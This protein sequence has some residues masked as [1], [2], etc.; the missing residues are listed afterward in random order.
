MSI[1][2][3]L[4]LG[5]FV[6]DEHDLPGELIDDDPAKYIPESHELTAGQVLTE[7]VLGNNKNTEWSRARMTY[8]HLSKQRSREAVRV[9]KLINDCAQIGDL[10]N[11]VED[12]GTPKEHGSPA[13]HYDMAQDFSW[14][15]W[16][17]A[18]QED[19]DPIDDPDKIPQLHWVEI[20]RRSY[21]RLE[22][23][24][25]TYTK[26]P[27]YTH[28]NTIFGVADNAQALANEILLLQ[29]QPISEARIFPDIDEYTDIHYDREER[30]YVKIP[31]RVTLLNA[32]G[33]PTEVILTSLQDDLGA[34]SGDLID[35]EVN[36]RYQED[37]D[38]E[39]IRQMKEQELGITS[40][41]YE[42]CN[43]FQPIVFELHK[44]LGRL[45]EDEVAQSLMAR[46]LVK[47]LRMEFR[48]GVPPQ[49]ISAFVMGLPL[50]LSVSGN[51]DDMIDLFG[52][53]ILDSIPP[54]AGMIT[55]V[56][57]WEFYDELEA[58]HKETL[59]MMAKASNK[60]SARLSATFTTEAFKAI[61]EDHLPIS[62]AT[63]QAYAT[64]RD[65]SE[66]GSNA[67]RQARLEK[68]SPS[69][70]M[71]AFYK[72]AQENG[73]F[74]AKDRI[75]TANDDRVV[76]LTSSSGYIEERELNWRLAQ[77][78]A[79]QGEIYIAKDA[80]SKSKIWLYNKLVSLGWSKDLI[81]N[82]AE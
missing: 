26:D 28:L 7:L 3:A 66:A 47:S 27:A 68:K 43:K 8:N 46:S 34:W 5:N 2:H 32:D 36:E 55:D 38:P 61:V 40:E 42:L 81:A 67:F 62:K 35:H 31:D 56:E 54:A 45:S 33:V 25:E 10:W 70:A 69:Q 71:R 12:K 22:Q 49:D 51:I 4:Q 79:K 75:S 20:Y 21:K 48:E 82:L 64:F 24:V 13:T 44:L 58:F 78:K 59:R 73:D 16:Q 11:L 50:E 80:P 14:H 23:M 29:T 72:V 37:H 57:D 19:V 63:S 9:W 15:K 41:Y 76:V 39:T 60:Y 30:D 53:D 6:F 74:I 65:I 52:D 17:L 1:A 77:Y 18:K